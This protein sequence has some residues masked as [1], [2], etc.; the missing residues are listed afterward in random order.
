MNNKDKESIE[1]AKQYIKMHKKDI[2]LMV[3]GAFVGAYIGYYLWYI[4]FI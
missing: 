1:E 2:V 4:D 3:L